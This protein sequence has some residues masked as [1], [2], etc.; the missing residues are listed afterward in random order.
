MTAEEAFNNHL[1]NINVTAKGKVIE[2]LEDDTEG[3]PHQK[4]V[5]ELHS[6]HTL[7]I[8]NNLEFGYRVPVKISDTVE[9]YGNFVWNHY[10]G[11]IHQTHHDDRKKHV[12]G[13][14]I[15]AKEKAHL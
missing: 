13:Y 12:D 11:V 3:T 14:I 9:V 10:G 8:V 1:S 4:F 5:I 7:L 6:G 15:L 2:I